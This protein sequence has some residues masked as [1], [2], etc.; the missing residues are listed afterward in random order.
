MKWNIIGKNQEH[1]APNNV[2]FHGGREG[3]NIWGGSRRKQVISHKNAS[4]K[5]W[6]KKL[7]ESEEASNTEETSKNV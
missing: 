2:P 1:Q 7:K 5:K 3:L 6:P 4:S